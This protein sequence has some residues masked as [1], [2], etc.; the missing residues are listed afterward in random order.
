ME[1]GE[2]V[3]DAVEV[4]VYQRD[5]VKVGSQTLPGGVD[6]RLIPVDADETAARRQTAISSEWPARPSVPST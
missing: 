6:G 4:A 1:I 5:A 2:D 3:A